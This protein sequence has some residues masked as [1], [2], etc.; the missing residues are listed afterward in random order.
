MTPGAAAS[1]GL[2][3][4]EVVRFLGRFHRPPECVTP[5]TLSQAKCFKM[6]LAYSSSHQE[7][8]PGTPS[9]FSTEET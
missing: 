6:R 9:F 8:V 2:L 7:G 1:L 4:I 5:V 3:D